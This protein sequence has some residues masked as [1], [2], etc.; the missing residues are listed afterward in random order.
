MVTLLICIFTASP[1]N[2]GAQTEEPGR[3]Q[4][5]RNAV[6]LSKSVQKVFRVGSLTTSKA[7]KIK[8]EFNDFKRSVPF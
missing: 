4:L 6:I 2:M 7:H 5:A 3:R 1:A 8:G